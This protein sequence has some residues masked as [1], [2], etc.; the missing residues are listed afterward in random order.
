M[1]GN[2]VINNYVDY[3]VYNAISTSV[4]SSQLDVVTITPALGGIKNVEVQAAGTYF[5]PYTTSVDGKIE[6]WAVDRGYGLSQSIDATP[7]T[8]NIGGP[9]QISGSIRSTFLLDGKF[10]G[11]GLFEVYVT[12]SSG[13]FISNQRV[14]RFSITSD[15]DQLS[16]YQSVPM[17]FTTFPTNSILLYSSSLHPGV[18][19]QGSA[20]QVTFSGSYDVT[21]LLV[22]PGTV[23]VMQYT[24]TLTGCNKITA[25][26][27]AGLSYIGGLPTNC[28]SFSAANCGLTELPPLNS[29]SLSYLN[30]PNNTIFTTLSPQASMSY[31]NVANNFNV[32][33]PTNL[34][35]GLTAL[36]AD[37]LGLTYTPYGLP[38]T[39]LTMSFANCTNLVSFLAPDLPTSL[40]WWDSHGSPLN[41]FPSL[42]PSNMLYVNVANCSLQPVTIGNVAAGLVTN[43]LSNGYL[44]FINNPASSSAFSIIPNITTL[45][46]RGWTIVS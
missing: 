29:G 40:G 27:N 46:G 17:V 12:A 1:A 25:D 26:G 34:P 2:I 42:M 36:I 41:N 20:S 8:F 45:R 7:I 43:G 9:D 44:S 3:G 33:L 31:I 19:Y 21:E 5:A 30:V 6:L 24:W 38:N 23:G 11:Y 16:V 39:L 37:G 18:A 28:V 10:S 4:S 15:C 32:T 22:P 35:P 13:V 14:T